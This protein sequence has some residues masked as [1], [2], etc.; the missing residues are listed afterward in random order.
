MPSE[1][2]SQGAR[3]PLKL[4]ALDHS[5]G[6]CP[7]PTACYLPQRVSLLCRTC[8]NWQHAT[9]TDYDV[10]VKASTNIDAGSVDLTATQLRFFPPPSP[11][12]SLARP[13]DFGLSIPQDLFPQQFRPLRPSRP[14]KSSRLQ[15]SSGRYVLV[16]LSAP[17]SGA[18]MRAIF[19][20]DKR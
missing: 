4:F 18:C 10:I 7:T 6:L 5:A 12:H 9:G 3:P 19:L 13:I 16:A 14:L 15:G 2:C 1:S 11:P 8:S 17:I 20:L